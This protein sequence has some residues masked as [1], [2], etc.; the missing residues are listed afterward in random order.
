MRKTIILLFVVMASILSSCDLSQDSSRTILSVPVFISNTDS[1]RSIHMDVGV[2]EEFT[3]EAK[4]MYMQ[5]AP[6]ITS[7]KESIVEDA[8]AINVE[9]AGVSLELKITEDED[10]VLYEGQTDDI[11]VYIKLNKKNRT[12]DYKQIT[13]I[14]A[15][16]TMEGDNEEEEY[17][18]VNQKYTC[19]TEGSDI[20]IKD[21]GGI[22]GSYESLCFMDTSEGENTS[23][24]KG[25]T[26]SDQSKSAVALLESYNNITSS[27]IDPPENMTKAKEID[28]KEID[29]SQSEQ[30]YP[31]RLYWQEDGKFHIEYYDFDPGYDPSEGENSYNAFE[32]INSKAS[33]LFNGEWALTSPFPE[34]TNSSR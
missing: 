29:E 16:V 8:S 25:E 28:L 2:G 27:K 19:I 20:S 17:I 1:S 33:E 12:F 13:F 22:S 7:F 30:S 15:T 9:I 32:Y 34:G 6:Y 31:L 23:I 3:A 14:E 11:Y 4:L 18:T 21:D 26:F 10:Y 24:L 5:S